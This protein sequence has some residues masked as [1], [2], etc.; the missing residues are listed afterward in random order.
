MNT[1]YAMALRSDSPSPPTPG[2]AEVLAEIPGVHIE[3]QSA[4]GAQ[5]TATP[6]ALALVRARFSTHFD[7]EEVIERRAN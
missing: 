1:K 6:Q 7:I 3:G 2:W 5:F 4:R